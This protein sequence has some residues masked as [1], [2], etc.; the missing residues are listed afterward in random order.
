MT[1]FISESAR[2]RELIVTVSFTD[3][4]AP[5]SI[6]R[7]PSAT[8][9]PRSNSQVRI[10]AESPGNDSE[11]SNEGRY[12]RHRDGRV[13]YISGSTSGRPS[14]RPMDLE[15]KNAPRNKD[16]R[17]K[18]DGYESEEG[19]ML[20][21][22]AP[23]SSRKAYPDDDRDADMGRRPKQSSRDDYGAAAA[24]GAAGAAA[25]RRPRGGPARVHY[26][27]DDDDEPAAPRSRAPRNRPDRYDERGYA[28]DRGKS[29]RH[30]RDEYAD[31]DA[32][33][34]PEASGS[35]RRPRGQG[36]APRS[37]YDDDYPPKDDRRPLQRS[38]SERVPR[39]TRD[40]YGRDER[41]ASSKEKANKDW[42]KQASA[43]FMSQAMPMIKKEGTRFVK[44]ELENYMK[45]KAR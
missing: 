27:Y 17:D 4:A 12:V 2:A 37:R 7:E 34:R 31:R 20:K 36:A 15:K 14:R 39:D 1:K 43:I 9:R 11:G 25:S 29:S 42:K 30:E 23:R 22:A 28:S 3:A 45:N 16:F 44:Q 19:E 41:G 26:D 40:R 35:N 32:R 13:E 18:R 21:K 8:G 10:R 38:R 6:L 24:G 33:R 5:K